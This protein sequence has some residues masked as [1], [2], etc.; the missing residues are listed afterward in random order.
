M[1]SS[2][3]LRFL[4]MVIENIGE[5]V[6][7]AD[8]QGN[9]LLF[10]R[11]AEQLLGMG[12]AEGSPEQ[13]ARTY[14]VF[15]PDEITPVD[16]NQLPLIRAVHGERTDGVELFI[17]NHRLPPEGV[18]ISVTGRPILGEDGR[19]DGAV[20]VFHDITQRKRTEAELERRVRERTAEL[21]TVNAALSLA[22]DDAE[23]ANKAKNVFMLNIGHEL[24]TPL[25]HILGY[26]EMLKETAEERGDTE[27]LPD[28]DRIRKAGSE[29]L[30]VI[31]GV[32]ELSNLEAGKLV[33][34]PTTFRVSDMMQEVL[35]GVA[36]RAAQNGNVIHLE[37]ARDAGILQLD[38]SRLAQAVTNILDNAARFTRN[39]TITV[40][41]ARDPGWIQ[42]SV[43]DTGPGI[44][45]ALQKKLFKE[46][47]QIDDSTTRRHGGVGLGLAITRRICRAMGGEVTATSKLGEGSVFTIR[48]PDRLPPN[49][50]PAP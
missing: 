5:G 27:S 23:A 47:S 15:L 28:L 33:L 41:V 22:R 14:G 11:A 20:I 4:E 18:H 50:S 36:G 16:P 35:A 13:W 17:R 38:R 43:A 45:P 21:A 34:A 1:N 32:L 44:E 10:N 26:S 37:T 49:T 2:L 48:I 42:I 29:L 6:V 8:S 19:L 40:V 3:G 7:V 9:F 12:A 39:G 46:F 31:S 30:A 24:R 25:N